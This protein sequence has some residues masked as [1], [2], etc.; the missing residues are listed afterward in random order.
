MVRQGAQVGLP[1]AVLLQVVL[2][3]VLQVA[4][5]V[6]LQVVLQVALQILLQTVLLAHQ[7]HLRRDSLQDFAV[8]G[9][10]YGKEGA[11]RV[12]LVVVDFHC[13]LAPDRSLEPTRVRQPVPAGNRPSLLV[14]DHSV[15]VIAV[16]VP[17]QQPPPS[18]AA[19][20]FWTTMGHSVPTGPF[21][22]RGPQSLESYSSA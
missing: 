9:L 20:N 3:A 1:Q 12:R 6:V 8:L 11:Q 2:Q 18:R 21:L 10:R 7:V 19:P 15:V 4:L 14:A 5:R 22:A 13:Y 16:A 17:R